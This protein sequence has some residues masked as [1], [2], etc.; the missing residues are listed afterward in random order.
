M[1]STGTCNR[2]VCFRLCCLHEATN[3]SNNTRRTHSTP[4]PGRTEP[5]N[6]VH[7]ARPQTAKQQR[8]WYPQR[9]GWQRERAHGEKQV[10]ALLVKHVLCRQLQVTQ[11]CTV[12][13]DRNCAPPDAHWCGAAML[14][15]LTSERS[16]NTF[17]DIRIDQESH[18]DRQF[19][20]GAGHHEIHGVEQQTCQRQAPNFTNKHKWA[21]L[22]R[23]AR[24]GARY[25]GVV[26]RRATKAVTRSHPG[27][28][29]HRL[30]CSGAAACAGTASRR[31]MP[32]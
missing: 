30:G 13:G 5:H 19:R 2:H 1:H 16:T 12:R 22:G 28:A 20:P 4:A 24:Q 11:A 18:R 31:Q 6:I 26:C 9:R 7:K 3:S 25:K 8:V 17:R 23:V 21:A 15:W 32:Q 10:V 14:A 29:A 27:K